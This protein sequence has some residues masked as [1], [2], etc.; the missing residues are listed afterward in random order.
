MKSLNLAWVSSFVHSVPLIRIT[1]L[2]FPNLPYL[3]DGDFKL[4]QSKAI[5]YYLSRKFGLLGKNPQEEAV[6][7]M[8][9]EQAHDL[10]GNLG[11]FSFTPN[12]DSES[13]QKKFLETTV[14]ENL[15]KFDTYLGK[16]KSK[17][18]VSDQP[19]V[20]D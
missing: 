18:A 14:A 19:T 1:H 6:V 5:L 13:E 16:N 3:I 4:T 20:A 11:Q 9:C 7:M 15:E 17:F 8:L 2:D 10:R 12:G